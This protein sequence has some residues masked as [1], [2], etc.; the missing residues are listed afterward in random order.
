LGTPVY[1]SLERV[2]SV[3]VII[4]GMRFVQQKLQQMQPPLSFLRTHSITSKLSAL[5]IDLRVIA[6]LH[7]NSPVAGATTIAYTACRD[8]KLYNIILVL[9]IYKRGCFFREGPAC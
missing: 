9:Y 6:V 4:V 3:D 1:R 7:S 5:V 2:D 8:D